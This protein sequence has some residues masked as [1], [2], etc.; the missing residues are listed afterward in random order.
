MQHRIIKSLAAL[1]L[2]AMLLTNPVKAQENN[3]TITMENLP[4]EMEDG[5]QVKLLNWQ[6]QKGLDTV[7][8][9]DWQCTFRGHTD[10]AFM[11]WITDLYNIHLPV[12]VESGMEVTIDFTDVTASGNRTNEQ[13]YRF[14]GP[15]KRLGQQLYEYADSDDSIAYR[16]VWDELSRLFYETSLQIY[17]DN[18]D[19]LAGAHI[20]GECYGRLLEFGRY[21][22]DT[23]MEQRN[24]LDSLYNAAP[25]SVRNYRPLSE[26]HQLSL[27]QRSMGKGQHFVDFEALDYA[28]GKSTRLSKLIKGHVAVVDFWASWCYPCRQEITEYLKPLYKKYADQGLVIVGVGAFDYPE[29]HLAGLYA[30]NLPYPHMLDTTYNG[31]AKLYGF[32]SLPQLFLI[33]RDGTVLGNFRGERLVLE[34]EK[35]LKGE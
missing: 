22:S 10:T 12:V 13:L 17:A 1:A 21:Y 4:I 15:E 20:L 9:N 2:G 30:M 3:Y 29:N 28:T 16:A 25:P 18:S 26:N 27:A 11:G 35:A 34:V 24:R 5:A 7:E 23:L 33:D 19:N 6:L 31:I 8:V 32:S 14:V